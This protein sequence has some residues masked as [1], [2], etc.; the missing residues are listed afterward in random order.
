MGGNRCRFRDCNVSTLNC[1]GIHF[2]RFPIKEQERFHKWLTFSG[3]QGIFRLPPESNVNRVVCG[4]HFRD[5]CFMNY[6]K[7]RIT[8]TAMPTIWRLS[9]NV[10]IDYEQDIENGVLIDLEPPSASHLIPP[11]DFKCPLNLSDTYNLLNKK[12]IKIASNKV[13]AS[14]VVPSKDEKLNNYKHSLAPRKNG[15]P[16]SINKKFKKTEV[17][18]DSGLHVLEQIVLCEANEIKETNE[19]VYSL[20]ENEG[21]T[22][23]EET[24]NYEY[25]VHD[26]DDDMQFIIPTTQ[27]EYD[28]TTL[29]HPA[30]KLETELLKCKMENESLKKQLLALKNEKEKQDQELKT[31]QKT[32]KDNEQ[33]GAQRDHYAKKCK[34]LKQELDSI[35]V[36][37][38]ESQN[39]W[40][41]MSNE[42]S[43][44]RDLLNETQDRNINLLQKI[45]EKD[46]VMQSLQNKLESL[47]KI[48]CSTQ[49]RYDDLLKEY[50]Q[51][52]Q[53]C[54]KIY[55]VS[56]VPTSNA[57]QSITSNSVPLT[58]AQI[59]NAIKRYLSATMVSLVRMEMFGSSEREWK[60]DERAVA[61]DIL[62]LGESIYNYFTEEWRFRLPALREVRSWIKEKTFSNELEEEL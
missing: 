18:V 31:T 29:T 50:E 17:K 7:D 48:N 58:K 11:L 9:K 21:L 40:S 30:N 20:R 35:Q 36:L 26:D 47:E 51:L 15:E 43:G 12:L 19:T 45:E 8:K 52:R 13:I 41:D 62:Q 59:F 28:P 23:D 27:T 56:S 10:A 39:Q 44:T 5:E 22:A 53:Q 33:L 2:F 38:K 6:K 54:D 46:E 34:L 42:L 57:P 1:P 14:T 24:V 49:T 3:N 25:E 4:R 60:P 16:G 55:Q 37:M 32:L 61:V